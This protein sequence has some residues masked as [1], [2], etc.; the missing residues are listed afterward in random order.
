MAMTIL[1]RNFDSHI[2]PNRICPNRTLRRN[3]SPPGYAGGHLHRRDRPTMSAAPATNLV[4]GQVKILKRGEPL[5]AFFGNRRSEIF[6]ENRDLDLG[7]GTTDRPGPDPSTTQ[8]QLRFS[9]PPLV[10]AG[11]GVYVNSP[12]PSSVPVPCFLG[13]VGSPSS[14]SRLLFGL[15]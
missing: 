15:E 7:L 10:Y 3:R 14:E 6:R 4:V 2:F 11:S 8:G 12:P 9:D 1:D 13:K 5:T